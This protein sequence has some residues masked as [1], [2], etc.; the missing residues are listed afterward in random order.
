MSETV[1]GPVDRIVCFAPPRHLYG[2]LFGRILP[3]LLGVPV[4]DAWA[5][6]LA[7]PPVLTGRVLLVCLPATWP[8]LQRS[9]GR[10][11]AADEVV[12]LHSTAAVPRA[13]HEVAAQCHAVE[14]LGSTETGAVAHR[15]ITAEGDP[16]EPWQLLPD[17]QADL[18]GTHERL[19]A[20]SGP[21]LARPDGAAHPPEVITMPD[22]VRPDGDRRFARLGRNAGMVKVNGRRC[23]LTDIEEYV[24]RAVPGCDAVAVPTPDAIRGEHYCLYY[25][26]AD[27]SEAELRTRFAAVAPAGTPA[28]HTIT[29]LDRVP[30]QAWGEL[31]HER[32]RAEPVIT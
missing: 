32:L 1:L 19:L 20:V 15:P 7:P 3:T 26:A 28:P 23:L 16:H 24:R 29:R 27:T 11:D 10:L 2:T 12:A 8:V 13:A 25:S 9:P 4:T 31:A 5:D 18:D 22:V 17:V 6:P 21:R 30:R 14:L